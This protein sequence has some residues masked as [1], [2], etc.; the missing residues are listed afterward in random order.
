MS[1]G[2]KPPASANFSHIHDFHLSQPVYVCLNGYP[3]VGK[4]TIAKALT[5]LLPKSTVATVATAAVV[6][7]PSHP[8]YDDLSLFRGQL[9]PTTDILIS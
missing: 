3:D 8:I 4:L 9:A 6:E 1:P 2:M 5:R 7:A